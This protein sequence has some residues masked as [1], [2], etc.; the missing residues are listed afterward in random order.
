MKFS[1]NNKKRAV[2]WASLVMKEVFLYSISFI[3]IA[4]PLVLSP[5]IAHAGFFSSLF[6]NLSGLVPNQAIADVSTN[7]SGTAAVSG[8][9][10]S[11]ENSQTLALLTAPI[12]S[13][14]ESSNEN[15]FVA[16]SSDDTLSQ[17]MN[18]CAATTT[19]TQISIY[20]VRPGDTLSGIANIFDVSVNTIL[21]ANNIDRGSAL[22]PGQTLVILP[23]SGIQY[24][25][26]KGDTISA[27][28]AHYNA[29]LN[30]ILQYNNITLSSALQTG[31]TIVIPDA[32]LG[33]SQSGAVS[34]GSSVQ[35]ATT[36]ST[37]GV[38]PKSQWGAPGT[39][40]AHNTNGPDYNSDYISPIAHGIETQGLHGYN[41]VDLAAPT[42][43]PI[44]AADAGTVIIARTGGWN[45]GYGSYV[46]ISHSNGTQTL[47]AHMSKVIASAGQQVAQGQKI[48]LVGATGE[49]TGPHVHFEVRGAQNPFAN[50]G[51]F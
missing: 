51:T 24:T 6:S 9:G 36:K 20:V 4:I 8:S 50:I 11:H 10:G 18:L 16:S 29:D 31:S 34:S 21:W 43:T 45:G 33:A 28:A 13:D 17:N 46:V 22:Q 38:L 25:V 41:A 7:S 32:E 14:P 3:F 37:K 2:P 48:G 23:I 40:P 42:G 5:A 15:C 44:V 30:E 12:N 26:K 47:Y 49:A 35:V 27:I 19:S 1:L 39:E